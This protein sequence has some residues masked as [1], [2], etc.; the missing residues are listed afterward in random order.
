MIL[1][2]IGRC[3]RHVAFSTVVT[4]H[5]FRDD[6]MIIGVNSKMFLANF[7]PECHISLI[8]IITINR[9]LL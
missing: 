5:I 4:L 8:S 1:N 2:A 6:A 3:I 9:S 7:F